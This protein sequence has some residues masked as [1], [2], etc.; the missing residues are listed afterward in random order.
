MM[1]IIKKQ[2]VKEK[3][4]T[5]WLFDSLLFRIFQQYPFV[6]NDSIYERGLPRLV[7]VLLFLNF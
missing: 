5:F 6:F 7:E 2:N 4:N 3:N 1:A